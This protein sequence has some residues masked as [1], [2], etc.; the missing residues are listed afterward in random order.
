MVWICSRPVRFVVCWLLIVA[1][2]IAWYAELD[3]IKALLGGILGAIIGVVLGFLVSA[4][5]MLFSR[6]RTGDLNLPPPN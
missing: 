4:L 3:Q 6:I 2:F 1:L 5:L